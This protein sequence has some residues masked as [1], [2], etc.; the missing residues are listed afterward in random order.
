MVSHDWIVVAAR[1]LN[2][3][4]KDEKQG[5]IDHA[6]VYDLLGRA[7][8]RMKK[9]KKATKALELGIS[10]LQKGVEGKSRDHDKMLRRLEG[11][12]DGLKS[13]LR[14]RSR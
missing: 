6:E 14:D 7:Y 8:M 4:L 12:L 1:H 9:Y 13:I 11:N 3:A 10:W 2:R 5:E